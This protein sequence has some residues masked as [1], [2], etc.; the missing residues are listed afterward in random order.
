MRKEFS[1][2]W[3]LKSLR[4]SPVVLLGQ[5]DSGLKS[6]LRLLRWRVS[7]VRQIGLRGDDGALFHLA[8]AHGMVERGL[9]QEL[10]TD[11]SD[12]GQAVGAHH[13]IGQATLGQHRSA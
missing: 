11:L 10:G 6:L 2:H 3:E 1:C 8:F 4:G 12:R 9:A 13:P 7:A 5:F